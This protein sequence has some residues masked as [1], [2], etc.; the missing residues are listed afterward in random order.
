MFRLPCC[1]RALV[2][3]PLFALVACASPNLTPVVDDGRRVDPA[4][5]ELAR[6][7]MQT[8]WDL[9]DPTYASRALVETGCTRMRRPLVLPMSLLYIA[10]ETDR[11]LASRHFALDTQVRIAWA[12]PDLGLQHGAILAAVGGKTDPV[13]MQ[14]L[15]A[16][17]QATRLQTV[18]GKVVDVAPYEICEGLVDTPTATQPD[19]AIHTTAFHRY[20]LELW[21]GGM[22][23]E[24][25]LWVVVWSQGLSFVTGARQRA[26]Q[27]MAA[28]SMVGFVVQHRAANYAA[29]TGYAEAD[30]WAVAAMRRLGHD[31]SAGLRLHGRLVARGVNGTPFVLNPERLAALTL[32]TTQ[33]DAPAKPGG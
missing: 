29:K 24:E 9:L 8:F 14:N 26:A 28:A 18:S 7:S 19:D 23:K 5:E 15:L 25:R 16:S 27:L 3:A 1:L 32:L 10:D 20:R 31:P 33:S 30:A 22:S 11:L 12:P 17:G 4:R 13:E 2:I 21:K 6:T